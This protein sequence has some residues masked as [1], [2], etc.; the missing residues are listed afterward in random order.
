MASRLPAERASLA[1]C[2]QNFCFSRPV[3]SSDSLRGLLHSGSV[4]GDQR[5]V[6]L[7]IEPDFQAALIPGMSFTPRGPQLMRL[8]D[9]HEGDSAIAL[10][11]GILGIDRQQ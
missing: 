4:S 7:Q 11:T 9:L 2:E 8:P 5:P 6:F 3:A 1:L 10:C